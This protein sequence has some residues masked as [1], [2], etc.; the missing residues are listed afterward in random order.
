M[1]DEARRRRCRS[2]PAV[3]ERDKTSLGR[4][5]ARRAACRR[6]VILHNKKVVPLAPEL[7]E[8]LTNEEL[9]WGRLAVPYARRPPCARVEPIPAWARDRRQAAHAAPWF[10]TNLTARAATFGSPRDDGPRVTDHHRAG[11]RRGTRSGGRGRRL[12]VP[13]LCDAMGRRSYVHDA[14]GAEEAGLL[15]RPV[16][17]SPTRDEGPRTLPASARSAGGSA[18]TSCALPGGGSR[19]TKP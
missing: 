10:G 8:V 18:A 14:S 7:V 17:S 15:V 6:R 16:D 2:P 12:S 13:T 19:P 4:F 11:R 9:P 5:F 1:R 3:R